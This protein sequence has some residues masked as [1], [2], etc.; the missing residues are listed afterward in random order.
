MPNLG[1]RFAKEGIC[2]NTKISLSA[3][4]ALLVSAFALTGC[5]TMDGAGTDVERAGE[6][7]QE[8]AK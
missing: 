6:K 8:S 5:N 4:L 7:I 2:M 1:I 3:L